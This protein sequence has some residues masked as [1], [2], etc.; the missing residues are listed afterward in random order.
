MLSQEFVDDPV[1]LSNWLPWGGLVREDVLL[2]KD[3]SMLGFI[4]YTPSPVQDKFIRMR[5][6]KDGWSIWSEVQH[7]EDGSIHYFFVLCWNPFFRKLTNTVENAISNVI[8]K[9]GE[10]IDYFRQE[11]HFLA[12]D[13]AKVFPCKVMKYQE[14]IDFLSFSISLGKHHLVMPETPL[15]L[16]SWLT[17]ELKTEF[18]ENGLKIDGE[19]LCV[20]S[21]PSCPDEKILQMIFPRFNNLPFRYVKRLICTGREAADKNWA[22]YSKKWCGSRNY[23]KE[24]I[25]DDVLSRMNGYFDEGLFFLVSDEV[26]PRVQNFCNQIM[27]VLEI[28]YILE[29]FNLKD[30]WW[31]SLPGLFRANINP[32]DIGF[33]HIDDLMFHVIPELEAEEEA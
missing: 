10:E 7:Y 24:A 22:V 9:K 30:V 16:D 12:Q 25:H 33:K 18:L 11:L 3:D 15:Y 6:F 4:E 21:L 29:A 27:T 31:G 8:K 19:N 5:N 13:M 32:P 14:I 26:L 17:Y 20:V 2:N 28:P 1:L 23:I